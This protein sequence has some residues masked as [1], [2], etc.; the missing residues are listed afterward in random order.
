MLRSKF[1]NT[2]KKMRRRYSLST[3]LV[4]PTLIVDTPMLSLEKPSK[5]SL[6]G[7]SLWNKNLN[8][9]QLSH[10]YQSL[11]CS[12]AEES[13]KRLRNP[14][15]KRNLTL[16]SKYSSS[17]LVI[18]PSLRRLRTCQSISQSARITLIACSN[19]VQHLNILKI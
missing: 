5:R 7:H 13:T 12:T 1:V 15:M 2:K 9:C 4:M 17:H 10:H 8:S 6:I 14:T 11:L 18:R 3:M 16:R 19:T